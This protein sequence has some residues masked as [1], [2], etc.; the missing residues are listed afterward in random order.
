MLQRAAAAD[1][2]GTSDWV[3]LDP[4][5]RQLPFDPERFDAVVA[6]SV[7]EYVDDPAAVLR[8]CRR[9]LRPGG[10]MLCTVPNVRHPV[11]WLEWLLRIPA[12]MPLARATNR[13]LPRLGSYL[14][15]LRTSRQH[16]T[17]QWW[18]RTANRAD[19]LSVQC[20]AD[21]AERSTLRLLA[22]QRPNP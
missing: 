9:M 2:V 15:Y 8:E 1:A 3:Q 10:L 12:W 20:T 6:A 7:L 16:H 22:F 19:L 21:S 4:G 14:T 13:C 17:A 11:R 5:W 18:S